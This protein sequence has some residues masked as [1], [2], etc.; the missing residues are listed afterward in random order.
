M[1]FYTDEDKKKIEKM[2]IEGKT[3]REIGEMYDTRSV[4]IES[5][6]RRANLAR[7]LH[8]DQISQIRSY[9]MRGLDD[10][11]IGRRTGLRKDSITMIREVHGIR[12]NRVEEKQP[13]TYEQNRPVAIIAEDAEISCPICRRPL[14]KKKRICWSCAMVTA[15]YKA[16][17][18]AI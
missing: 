7:H 1:N 17:T 14:T 9:A 18:G 12:S 6:A 2:L 15:H 16:I 3:T 5:L 13:R 8:P 10:F 11:S 4:N